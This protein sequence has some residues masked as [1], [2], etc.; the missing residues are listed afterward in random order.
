MLKIISTYYLII[1]QVKNLGTASWVL[2][3]KVSHKAAIRCQ[4]LLQSPF[5]GTRARS[6][7]KLLGCW[8]DAVAGSLLQVCTE[9]LLAIGWNFSQFLDS[10]SPMHGG[11]LH[12]S[13]QVRG[14]KWECEK[15]GSHAFYNLTLGGTLITFAIFCFSGAS[16]Q[17][18]ATH[19]IIGN[20]N[21]NYYLS[22]FVRSATQEQ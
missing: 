19:S 3:L 12:Q 1:L 7:S 15:K 6:A 14:A 5:D 4:L 20:C 17:V 18:Q 16:C 9:A 21:Y 2:R 13:K 22:L 8:Q 10:W 11:L